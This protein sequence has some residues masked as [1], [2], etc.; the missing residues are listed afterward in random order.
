[1]KATVPVST[2]VSSRLRLLGR[3]ERR[4]HV[5]RPERQQEAAG[6]PADAKEQAF[7]EQLANEAR[8]ARAKRQ[9]HRHFAVASDRS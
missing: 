6:A 1:M 3:K 4:Q 7:C 9:P 2:D 8:P 5:R